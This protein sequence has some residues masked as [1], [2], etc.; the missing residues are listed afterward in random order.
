MGRSLNQNNINFY[1][2]HGWVVEKNIFS[3]GEIKNIKKEI[4]SFLKENIKSYH[5]RDINFFNDVPDINTVNSFHRMDDCPFVKK[6]A[7]NSKIY[8]ISKKYLNSKKPDL[9]ACELFAKPRLNGLPAPIHQ[10]NFYWCVNDANA[11]TVWLALDE[12]NE[13]NGGV[14]YYD[15]SHKYGIFEHVPSYAKGSSQKI[16]NSKTLKKYEISTPKLNIGDCVIHHC[17]TAHGSKENKSKKNRRGLTF[18][19]KSEN[20]FYDDELK[21]I[22]EKS[23]NSQI[24]RRNSNIK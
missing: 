9:R 11:L 14:F 4:N 19:F 21:I 8:D 6:L 17:L 2:M 3:D 15:G 1:N 20:S 23:L 18:Q 16:K 10:D 13:K 22:Y 7:L 24:L 12:T 5:G